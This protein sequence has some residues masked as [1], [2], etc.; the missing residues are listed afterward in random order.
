[1]IR[2]SSAARWVCRTCD[3]SKIFTTAPN[4]REL[5]C[6]GSMPE[7]VVFNPLPGRTAPPVDRSHLMERIPP[8]QEILGIDPDVERALE[9]RQATDLVLLARSCWA[10]GL[11][12][13]YVATFAP[14][15]DQWGVRIRLP[16]ATIGEEFQATV[17]VT[18][19]M[20]RG[21]AYAAAAG[22]AVAGAVAGAM[23]SKE[24]HDQA[25]TADSQDANP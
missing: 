12:R 14:D 23:A 17:I 11:A 21:S 20:L 4:V 25:S 19:E 24:R 18:G 9:G 10:L 1:M 15:L 16:A 2:E 7:S 13:V 22:V 5:R 6:P 3:P 8:I